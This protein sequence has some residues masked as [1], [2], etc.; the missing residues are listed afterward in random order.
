VFVMIAGAGLVGQ[1]ITKLLSK[2]GHDVVVVD[3]DQEVC[4]QIYAETGAV[5]VHGSATS[6]RVLKDAGA[7]KAD[8]IVC[9][10][11]RDA[12]NIACSIIAQ[13]LG[14][15]IRLAR[16]KDPSYEEAYRQSGIT[17]IMRVADLLIN[18]LMVEIEQPEVKKV[19][20]LGGADVYA[21]RIPP[22][23][24]CIDKPVSNIGSLPEFPAESLL[25]GVFRH[26]TEEFSIPR[27]SFVLQEGDTIFLIARP[28]DVKQMADI[29]TRSRKNR[30][31]KFMKGNKDGS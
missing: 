18:Q 1:Q 3:I 2:N 12:D 26:D 17:R 29:L 10:M 23:A 30:L 20:S 13:S 9:L 27:G 5:S 16:L 22:E 24:W 21:I 11:G 8:V 31:M 14:V 15:P 4:E 6:L 7:E 28:G 25:M 19:M